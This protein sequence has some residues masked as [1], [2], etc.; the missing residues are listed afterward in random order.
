MIQKRRDRLISTIS[1]NSFFILICVL[2]LIPIILIISISLSSSDAIYQY[3]YS[4]F[5]KEINFDAY[6]YLFQDSTQIVQSY[7][8]TI[9]VVVIG[10]IASLLLTAMIAYP[11]SREH[12][13]LKNQVSFIVFFTMLFNGGLVPWYILI[14]NYLHL[15]DTIWVLILPYLISA[16]NVILM[17]TFFK[18]IPN[19]VLEAAE[20]DGA[21]EL[22]IFIKMVLPMSK[23][24]LATIGLLTALRYWNDWWLGMLFIEKDEL[25]PL[26]YLLYRLMTNIEELKNDALQGAATAVMDLPTEP[27]RMAMAVIAAGPMLLIFP[28]FQKYFVKGLTVGAVK[29]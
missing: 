13:K 14:T 25:I 15:K 16:W 1:I 28:F 29:G 22:Q 5:P 17:R 8:V 7:W 24:G 4:L 27:A 3:G 18:S 26:Q 10:G 12:Y 11:L 9:R 6:Q 19:E 23:P 21:N 20:I 2:F